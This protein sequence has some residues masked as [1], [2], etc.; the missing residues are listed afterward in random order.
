MI[1]IGCVEYGEIRTASITKIWEVA[2]RCG[3][4]CLPHP[5]GYPRNNKKLRQKKKL[6]LIA[7]NNKITRVELSLKKGVSESGIKQHLATLKKKVFYS[8]KEAGKWEIAGEQP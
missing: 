7:Q 4:L 3:S 6:R 2:K 5:T 1:K 8:D